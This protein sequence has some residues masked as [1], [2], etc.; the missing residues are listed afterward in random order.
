[1]TKY[2]IVSI[3]FII[4]SML[5]INCCDAQEKSDSH[6]ASMEK[7]LRH[8]LQSIDSDKTTR[9][10]AAFLDLNGDG[11]SEAVVYLVG[12]EWCGSGGCTTM[13]LTQNDSSWKIINKITITRPP[14]RVLE[15]TYNGWHSLGVW[16][17][18]GGIH[19]GYE[20]ELRFN[21][22]KYPRNPSVPPAIPLKEK[23]TG[24][25]IISPKQSG[26]SL[27]E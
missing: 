26:V 6:Q 10:I 3:I 20:A 19:E 22:K 21:G 17:Q 11:K 1:M 5:L 13:I 24:E 2:R 27:Y 7:S 16:V 8:Y 18:G 25:V 14:I 23:I 15:S 9:Y 12:G 4:Y